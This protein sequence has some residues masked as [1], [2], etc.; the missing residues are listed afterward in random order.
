MNY[1]E[2]QAQE[3]EIL[4]SIYTDEEFERIFLMEWDPSNLQKY[5]Q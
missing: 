4:T 5:P 3:L 1:E 2:E